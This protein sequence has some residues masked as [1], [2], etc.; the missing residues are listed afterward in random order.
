M[1]GRPAN[2]KS[3]RVVCFAANQ[4]RSVNV[5]SLE[6]FDQVVLIVPHDDAEVHFS[7]AVCTPLGNPKHNW[8]QLIMC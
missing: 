6:L 5:A 3:S 4:S 8:V 2:T 1:H 7:E